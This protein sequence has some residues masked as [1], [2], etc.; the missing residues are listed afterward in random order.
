MHIYSNSVESY[1]HNIY[2]SGVLVDP[3]AEDVTYNYKA[4]DGTDYS[5]DA[6]R[7]SEGVYSVPI[8]P[9]K[10]DGDA[11]LHISYEIDGNSIEERE[12]LVFSPPY[13]NIGTINE[14]LP[15]DDYSERKKKERLVASVIN[16]FCG[17]SFGLYHFTLRLQG[18]GADSLHSPT[19]LIDVE[20]VVLDDGTDI[21][22][23]AKVSDTNWS[24]TRKFTLRS[25]P[26]FEDRGL[27][28]YGRKYDITGEF[29]WEFV[30][31]QI[32]QAAAILIKDYEENEA[33]WREK[34]V[35]VIRAADW[36]M[37]FA[38]KPIETTGNINADL[39][40]SRFV[41]PRWAVI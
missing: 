40:I 33:K 18:N 28:K 35:D 8:L 12:G 2:S 13:A 37:E 21:S 23:Y 27:F 5:G 17:Q 16:A 9:S 11:V 14:L 36:R 29:G 41:V 32:S 26:F 22:D 1:L 19:R 39:L 3:D 30:P 34:N 4:P 15:D 31:S 6:D 38:G 7:V 20:S 24:V 10:Y 25:N